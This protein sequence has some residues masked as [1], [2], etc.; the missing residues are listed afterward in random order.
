MWVFLTVKATKFA[1]NR[2][3]MELTVQL[4][5]KILLAVIIIGFAVYFLI[6]RLPIMIGGPPV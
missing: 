2:K 6:R 5:V 4:L 3:A 1:A